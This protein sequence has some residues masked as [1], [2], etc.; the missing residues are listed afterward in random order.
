MAS[1]EAA[2]DG[3]DPKSK[4]GADFK[5]KSEALVDAIPTEILAPYTAILAV[6]VANAE[7]GAWE[8]GRW[9]IYGVGAVLSPLAIYLVWLSQADDSKKRN[10]PIAGMV[11]STVAFGA[12]GFVMPGA[13]LS[14]SVDEAA[15]VT[16]WTFLIV[17]VSTLLIAWLPLNKQTAKK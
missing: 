11:G 3:D 6:I 7:S 5:P 17:T 4:A 13:P 16:I 10:F 2:R 1:V 12:W 15:N 9:I 14:F 8:V